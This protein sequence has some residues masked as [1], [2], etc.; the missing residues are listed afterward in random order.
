MHSV[1]WP[2]ICSAEVPGVGGRREECL[3]KKWNTTTKTGV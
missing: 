1:L 3:Y 2:W